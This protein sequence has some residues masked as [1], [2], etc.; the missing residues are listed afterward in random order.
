MRM[1]EE[2]YKKIDAL[3]RE[4]REKLLFTA[5][6]NEESRALAEEAVQ[7]TFQIACQEADKCCNSPNP[8][9]WLVHTLLN[10][11]RNAKK[12]RLNAQKLIEDYLA[13]QI[14]ERYAAMDRLDVRLLYQNVADMEEFKLLSEMAIEGL[15]HKEMAKRRNISVNACKK[16]VQR[17]KELLQEKLKNDVTQ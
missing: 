8:Q 10:V 7:E 9:G 12:K 13:H 2:Q 14:R 15:S 1:T 17:A 11:I 4:M 3:Y 5:L 16:R 6:R